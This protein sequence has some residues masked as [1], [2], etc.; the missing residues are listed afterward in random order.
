MPHHY[1]QKKG[2]D[3]GYGITFKE[4]FTNYPM[5][6]NTQS[7]YKHTKNNK[8]E[9]K[10]YIQKFHKLDNMQNKTKHHQKKHIKTKITR[11]P[12]KIMWNKNISN[13]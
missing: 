2:L 3:F 8:F 4:K 7:S 13:L 1:A 5:L 6:Y 9:K 12:K 11:K 10:K